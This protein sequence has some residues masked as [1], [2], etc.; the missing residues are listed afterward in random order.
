MAK[1]IPFEGRVLLLSWPSFLGAIMKLL[2]K[3]E[4]KSY[5]TWPDIF[6]VSGLPSWYS[7]NMKYPE[8]RVQVGGTYEEY[9]K[10]FM[11]ES[12]KLAKYLYKVEEDGE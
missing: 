8:I 2:T 3:E 12:T 11:L 10:F 4:F 6:E 7:C 1:R 5:D 9:V